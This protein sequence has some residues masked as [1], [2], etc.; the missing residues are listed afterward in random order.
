MMKPPRGV[1]GGFAFGLIRV[2]VIFDL[3]GLL[4]IGPGAVAAAS[5][6]LELGVAR[7]MRLDGAESAESNLSVL[8]EPRKPLRSKTLRRQFSQGGR[9]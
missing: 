8:V 5:R 2:S 7:L 6:P 1:D 9:V 3:P 4:M